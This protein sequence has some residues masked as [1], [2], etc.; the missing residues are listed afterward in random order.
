MFA[1][2][3][4]VCP[5]TSIV[6]CYFPGHFQASFRQLSKNCENIEKF[7]SCPQDRSTLHFLLTWVSQRFSHF[8]PIAWEFCSAHAGS[9]HGVVRRLHFASRTEIRVVF[10]VV[11]GPQNTIIVDSWIVAFNDT[12]Q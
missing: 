9:V 7:G 4:N 11:L 10:R 8:W 2:G 3:M 12:L 1:V 5:S 6:R